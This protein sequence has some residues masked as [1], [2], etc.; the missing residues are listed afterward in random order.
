VVAAIAVSY[1]VAHR[2]PKF[3]NKDSI[4]LADF[5]NNAGDAVFDDTL[6]QGLSV[7]IEQSP[8]LYLVSDSKVNATL[9]L[10]GAPPATIDAGGHTRGVLA[11]G[12]HGHVDRLD[13]PLGQPVPDWLAVVDCNNGTYWQKRRSKRQT[14]KRC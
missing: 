8:F 14:R 9:K 11:H 1:F 12:Q 3:T 10:M 2:P 13:C 4:V 5:D 7:Q 6:K